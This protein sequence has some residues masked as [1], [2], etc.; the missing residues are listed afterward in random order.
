[1]LISTQVLVLAVLV[2]IVSTACQAPPEPEPIPED[3]SFTIVLEQ[4]LATKSQY[5]EMLSA[6]VGASEMVDGLEEENIQD[7]SLFVEEDQFEAGDVPSEEKKAGEDEP[8][9]LAEELKR[10]LATAAPV[11]HRRLSPLESFK[12][13]VTPYVEEPECFTGVGEWDGTVDDGW[14]K[15]R[16]GFFRRQ[17]SDYSQAYEEEE[18]PSSDAIP[19]EEGAFQEEPDQDIL[20]RDYPPDAPR[21]FS[22]LSLADELAR[23]Q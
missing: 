12:Q 19:L 17:E 8:P 16:E 10:E 22:G 9:T 7:A 13:D 14:E 18:E 5:D 3:P 2:A 20:E 11:F 6:A 4:V 1:M 15:V 23:A 21:D